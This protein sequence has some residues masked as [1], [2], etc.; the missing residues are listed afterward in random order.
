MHRFTCPVWTGNL[1]YTKPI[2]TPVFQ[3]TFKNQIS[4][5]RI[6]DSSQDWTT[7][8]S[9]YLEH[10]M[11]HRWTSRHPASC[12]W[13][14]GSWWTCRRRRWGRRR[15]RCR[16]CQPQPSSRHLPPCSG[17]GQRSWSPHTFSQPEVFKSSNFLKRSWKST[18]AFSNM[19]VTKIIWKW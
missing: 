16:L 17:Q 1:S 10:F 9:L 18:R 5:I 2:I 19:H 3:Q 6:R 15:G 12:T 8:Y 13:S 14:C 7:T 11:A 4:F